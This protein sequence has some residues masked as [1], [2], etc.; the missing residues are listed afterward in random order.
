MSNWT[1]KATFR[2]ADIITIIQ[3]SDVGCVKRNVFCD[4]LEQHHYTNDKLKEFAKAFRKPDSVVADIIQIAYDG[5]KTSGIDRDIIEF[6]DSL[7]ST[8]NGT[9]YTKA[10]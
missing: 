4:Y 10:C 5:L 8:I 3:T 6:Y 2:F 9:I 1:L 7:D